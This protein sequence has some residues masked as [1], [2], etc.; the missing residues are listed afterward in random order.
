MGKGLRFEFLLPAPLPFAKFEKISHPLL[1][2][3][4]IDIDSCEHVGPDGGRYGE[5]FA[6]QTNGYHF[7]PFGHGGRSQYGSTVFRINLE[8]QVLV[9]PYG[10]QGE[11]VGGNVGPVFN[12][13]Q[14]FA[15]ETGLLGFGLRFR[16]GCRLGIG[17]RDRN[18]LG[19]WFGRGL[20]KGV[21]FGL[22][23]GLDDLG[24]LPAGFV[25]V[26]S[27]VLL[28]FF[29]GGKEKNR[30]AKER[31]QYSHRKRSKKS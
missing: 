5:G 14:E 21:G 3:G 31:I 27:A 19:G 12:C 26:G 6:S 2:V 28:R 4:L 30:Q 18:R 25:L 24:L 29:A 22:G 8:H 13:S 11:N 16:V 9:D 15:T 10:F 17:H 7:A 1:E 23:R 20:G